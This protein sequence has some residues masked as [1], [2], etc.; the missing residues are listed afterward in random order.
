MRISEIETVTTDTGT[1]TIDGTAY[2]TTDYDSLGDALAEA[3]A[4]TESLSRLV[5]CGPRPGGTGR[6]FR[7]WAGRLGAWIEVGE[8]HV[9]PSSLNMRV[10][11]DGREVRVT[12]AYSWFGESEPAAVAEATKQIRH[13]VAQSGARMLGSPSATGTAML[14]AV[15]ARRSWE[16]STSPA[17]IQSALR[18]TSGQGRFELLDRGRLRGGRNLYAV[19]ARFQY[20][21]IARNIEVG[22]GVPVDL[23]PNDPPSYAAAWVEVEVDTAG[24]PYPFGLLGVKRGGK[25]EYPYVGRFT[26]WAHWCE[27]EYARAHG[28]RCRV[29]GGY[30]WPMRSRALA[31]WAVALIRAREAAARPGLDSAT[32][33][34]SR[35]AC[36]N[37]VIQSIGAM[38]GRDVLRE[39]V[40]ADS[41]EIPAAAEGWSRHEDRW[42]YQIREASNHRAVNSH[43]EWT[44]HLWAV[45]RLRLLRRMMSAPEKVAAVALD[46]LYVTDPRPFASPT[47]DGTPG[48]WRVTKTAGFWKPF[49]TMNDV[50]AMFEVDQ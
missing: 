16:F 48:R 3:E 42:R 47:D 13:V 25:W 1:V 22:V 15:H 43:P 28:Y 5:L 35:S 37:M 12:W 46:A 17:E 27:V 36:R 38:H 50:Y 21:A 40:V 32:V 6:N 39:Y 41:S 29:L 9:S 24:S 34:A 49:R 31:P 14:R 4:A 11:H 33:E 44:T 23:G 30:L 7:L 8:S 26:T 45:A 19:D 2:V 10:G 18:Q 20:A